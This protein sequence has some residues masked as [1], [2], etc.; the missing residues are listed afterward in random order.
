MRPC[1][2][3]VAQR[4]E[5]RPA[6]REGG[7]TADLQRYRCKVTGLSSAYRHILKTVDADQPPDD[8]YQQGRVCN[9][10]SWPLRDILEVSLIIH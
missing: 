1:D 2:E 9:A 3:A 4:A 6:A 10:V 8:V 5:K 7:L